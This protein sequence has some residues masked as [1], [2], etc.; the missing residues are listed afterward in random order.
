MGRPLI[1][2]SGLRYGR[3]TVVALSSE[4]RNK[5]IDWIC[6]C[7]CGNVKIVSSKH[8]CIGG[9][10]NSC[11][12]ILKEINTKRL[13]THGYTKTGNKQISEYYAWHSMKDRCLNQNHHAYKNYGGRGITICDEWKD[14]FECFINDMGFKPTKKHTLDRINNELGYY[15]DNCRWAL[16]TVQNKNRRNNVWYELRGRRMISADWARLIG[17][18]PGNLIASLKI[19]G[20]LEKLINN[21]EKKSNRI[22]L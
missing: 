12:C 20:T 2:K 22:I 9:S 11:G 3:L 8:L 10:I 1:D 19:H 7:D 21:Y 5:Y 15:K 4:K 6:K 13:K 14:S 17:I 18:T 16:M